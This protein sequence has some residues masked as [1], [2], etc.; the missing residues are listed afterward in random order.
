MISAMITRLL[1]G[2]LY[3]IRRSDPVTFEAT[4]GVLL[5]V[6]LAASGIPA[7]RAARLDPMETLR[8]Q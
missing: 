7:C 1:S 4:T 3:G 5:L 2:M 8:E 6:S